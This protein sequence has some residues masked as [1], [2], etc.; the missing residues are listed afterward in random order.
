MEE[1]RLQSLLASIDI[2]EILAAASIDYEGVS[3]EDLLVL[4]KIAVHCCVNGPVGVKKLTT[5]P[6]VGEAKIS[7]LIS[8]TNRT[9][10]NFC[11]TVKNHLPTGLGGYMVEKYG[12]YWPNE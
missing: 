10:K 9:W 12:E 8:C 11:R 4:L 6:N 5:F 1:S 2:R 3:D 7:N